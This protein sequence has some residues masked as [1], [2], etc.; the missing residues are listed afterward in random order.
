MKSANAKLAKRYITLGFKVAML[1]KARQEVQRLNNELCAAGL[2]SWGGGTTQIELGI[3]LE[4]YFQL[5][6]PDA[7]QL[8]KPLTWSRSEDELARGVHQVCISFPRVPVGMVGGW[9][10][11][12][13]ATTP[14]TE[15][16]VPEALPKPTA[17][18]VEAEAA[19]AKAD[20]YLAENAVTLLTTGQAA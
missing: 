20:E 8:G 9:H 12:V 7:P 13:K 18:Q 14:W 15:V 3:G 5:A 10:V 2:S 17:E 1:E 4:D 16:K 19:A 6:P 11:F